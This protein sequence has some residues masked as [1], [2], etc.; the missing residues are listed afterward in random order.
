MLEFKHIVDERRDELGTSFV[1]VT[2]DFWTDP[3][4]K[5]SFGALLADVTA[6][7][8]MLAN[9]T[10]FFMSNKTAQSLGDN[11]ISSTVCLLCL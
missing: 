8:Y 1:S 11:I 9:G 3:H 5:D 7:K 6:P 10:S 2:T 4:Q